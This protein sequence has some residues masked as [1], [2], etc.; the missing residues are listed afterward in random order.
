MTVYGK[1]RV[2]I[3]DIEEYFL[4]CNK[5]YQLDTNLRNLFSKF[6]LDLGG[7]IGMYICPFF[8]KLGQF[9]VI[10]QQELYLQS[11]CRVIFSE[12][13]NSILSWN[14]FIFIRISFHNKFG[15]KV[16]RSCFPI[17]SKGMQCE[18]QELKYKYL[19]K[20]RNLKLNQ[21]FIQYQYSDINIIILTYKDDEK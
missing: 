20:W 6:Y 11:K 4:Q 7:S 5:K 15:K 10:Q 2:Y 14:S 17:V 13:N 19:L 8:N 16:S 18:M 1:C 12:Q 9:V 3:V 21:E